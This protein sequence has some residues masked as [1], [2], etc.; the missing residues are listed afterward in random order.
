[1]FVLQP[2]VKLRIT[3]WIFVAFTS[4]TCDRAREEV[5][6]SP[7]VNDGLVVNVLDHAVSSSG[8]L[9]LQEKGKLLQFIC[10]TLQRKNEKE[11]NGI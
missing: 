11:S 3:G 10:V 6:L 9:Y 8:K 1:M 2:S 5:S 7:A 4:A